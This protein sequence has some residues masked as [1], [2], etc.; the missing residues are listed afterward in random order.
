MHRLLLIRHLLFID[1]GMVNKA[2]WP[3]RIPSR[4]RVLVIAA[5]HL[6]FNELEGVGGDGFWHYVRL[7]GL[8]AVLDFVAWHA[9]EH[10]FGVNYFGNNIMLTIDES[11]NGHW[12]GAASVLIM[13]LN[14]ASQTIHLAFVVLLGA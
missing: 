13:L 12:L 9:L 5:H 10:L 14:H 2:H 4:R 1:L 6:L 11:G 3:S 8:D 7:H